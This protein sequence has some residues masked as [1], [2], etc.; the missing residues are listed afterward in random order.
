M[1]RWFNLHKWINVTYHINRS[2]DKK[3]KTTKTKNKKIHMIISLDT[4][5]AFNKIQIR[6]THLNIIEAIY[7][8]STTYTKLS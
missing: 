7:S 5:K 8:K 4:E 6:K 1:Q 2:K 3:Q